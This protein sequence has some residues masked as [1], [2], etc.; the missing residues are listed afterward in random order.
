M[1]SKGRKSPGGIKN[2]ISAKT[3]RKATPW[4]ANAVKSIGLSYGEVFKEISPNIYDIA[5]VS[6]KS[7]NDLARS[8]RSSNVNNVTNSLSNNR[9]VKAGQNLIKNTIADLK[10]GNFNNKD[11]VDEAISNSMGGF[12]EFDS[13]TFFDDWDFE[14]GDASVQINNYSDTSGFSIAIDDSMKRNTEAQLKGH[15]ANIDTMIAISSAQMMQQ[16]QLNSEIIG[17]LS[18][19]SSGINALVEFNNSTLTSFIE[20]STAYMERLGSKVDEWSSGNSD[21]VDPASV[22]RDRNGG[23]NTSNYINLVKQNAKS[24][25]KNSDAGF[26]ADMMDDNM[27]A[28]VTANPL[29]AITQLALRQITP[30]MIKNSLAALDET[31]A[32]FIPTML[33]KVA[34]MADDQSFGIGA[35]IRRGFGKMFGLKI[36]RTNEFDMENKITDK[37]VPFDQITRHA[38][39]EVIP[40]YLREQTAYLEAIARNMGVNTRVSKN[41]A[42]V[43][44]YRR[45]RY[46][47]LRDVRE[48]VYGDIRN[49]TISR[50]E[51][52]KFGS[53]LRD[54]AIGN[55]ADQETYQRMLD[56]LFVA[57][58]RHGK[59]LNV[60]DQS[61]DSDLDKII[62]ALGYSPN[63]SNHLRAAL[64][65]VTA[66]PNIALNANAAIMQARLSRNGTINDMMSDPTAYNL[67]AAD[68][69]N[70]IDSG[71]KEVFKTSI[72]DP[73]KTKTGT[74]NDIMNDVRFILNRGIN[75]K[76]AGYG[77][78]RSLD[79][80]SAGVKNSVSN[81]NI[82]GSSSSDGEKSVYDGKNL[83]EADYERMMKEGSL[84][85]LFRSTENKKSNVV[86]G[87][88]NFM[89]ALAFGSGQQA[90]QELV[91]IAG[92]E[93]SKIG[94]KF[95]DEF[96]LPMKKSIFGDKDKDGY[97]RDGLF[98]G[99]QNKFIDA[100]RAFAR[101]FNGK[102]YTDSHGNKIA[103][104]KDGE[105]SVLGNIRKFTH[106]TI[107]I[108]GDYILGEKIYSR[109]EN[110]GIV[111]KGKRDKSKGNWLG[112]AIGVL[113][114]GFKGWTD[115]IFGEEMSEENKKKTLADIKKKVSDTLPSTITGAAGG[116]VFN[117]LAGS[118]LLGTLIG[119][120]MGGALLGATVG[121][122]SKSERFN[123]WLFG[124][125]FVDEDGNPQ[126]IEGLISKKV[127]DA[128]KDNK[129][130]IVGGAILG[131]GK[132]ML[133]GSGGGLLPSLVGGPFAGAIIGGSLSFLKNTD[134]FQKFLY[135][136]ADEGGWHKGIVNMFNGIFKNSETG[137]VSGRRLAGMNI[138][139][140]LGGGLTAAMVGK[141]GLLGAAVTPFGPIGGALAGLALSMKA[142]KKGF[143]Q[144]LFGSDEVDEDGNTRHKVG[145]LGKFAN[146]LDAELF[147]P[148]KSGMENFLDD[149]KN[150]IIDKVMA[151]VEFALEPLALTFKRVGEGIQTKI[152]NG[153]DAVTDMV[154]SRV[155]K[156]LNTIRDIIVKPIRNVFSIFFKGITGIAKTIIATPF[157]GLALATNFMDARAKRQSRK[158]VMRENRE[159]QG[160][161][162]G[163][164][165]N[166]AIRFRYGDAYEDAS[167][168]YVDYE[169]YENSR[170][171][172]QQRYAE[173]RDARLAET[174]RRK[175]ERRYGNKNRQLIAKVTG[176]LYDK[177]T[178]EN[179]AIA[180]QMWEEQLAKMSPLRRALANETLNFRG[181]AV[182]ERNESL[183]KKKN[184]LTVKNLL[185]NADKD[186]TS[187]EQKTAGNVIKLKDITTDIRSDIR[188]LNETLKKSNEKS[189][190]TLY[191]IL[192]KMPDFNGEGGGNKIAETLNKV[193]SDIVDNA[194]KIL[195]GHARGGK[196]KGG[197]VVVGENGPEIAFLPAGTEI[198]PN[199][200]SSNLFNNAK[201]SISRDQAAA[202]Y[203]ELK[204]QG[205]YE[206]QMKEKEQEQEKKYKNSLLTTVK[207]IK[208][209]TGDYT[210]GWKGIF[211]KKG[212]ITAGI[213]LLAPVALK[214][215]N[216]ILNLDFGGLLSSLLGFAG[217][218]ASRII[219]DT[220][221]G[222]QHLGDNDNSLDKIQENIEETGDLLHGD[223]LGW[224]APDGELDHQSGAKVNVLS[225]I[226]SYLKKGK[227]WLAKSQLGKDI[228]GA[229]G[230][231]KG[232]GKGLA[233]GIRGVKNTVG[234]AKNAFNIIRSGS[235]KGILVSAQSFKH[236]GMAGTWKEAITM[237]AEN[238]GVTLKSSGDD[239]AKT[240]S[241]NSKGV[242][243]VVKGAFSKLSEKLMAILKKYSKNGSK[244]AKYLDDIVEFVSK[245]SGKL[246]TKLQPL[247][248]KTG[249]LAATGVGLLA[250]EVVMVTVGAI[251]GAT[252]PA[253]LFQVDNEYVD[254]WMRAISAAIGGFAGSTV[255]SILD[256]VNELV[257]DILGLDI[258][259]EIAC[260]VYQILAGDTK[261][262][263]LLEGKDEFRSDFEA[264]EASEWNS[265]YQNYLSKNGL[266]EAD[267]SLDQFKEQ[268]N[269][270]NIS[271][272]ITSFADY[273]DQQHK[274]LG[275]RIMGGISSIGKGI[276][277][278]GNKIIGGAKNVITGAGSAVGNFAGNVASGIGKGI[279]AI[280]GGLM[281]IKDY[282]LEAITGYSTGVKEIVANFK[283]TDNTLFDYLKADIDTGISDENPFAKFVNG[284]LTVGKV[285]ML[286]KLVISGILGK[287]GNKI[288]DTFTSVADI[289]IDSAKTVISTVDTF[290]QYSHAGDVEGLNN[291]AIPD[292]KD[293]PINGLLHGIL[294]VAKIMNVPVAYLFKIGGSIK[295]AFV[296]M[297]NGVKSI[298]NTAN[299]NRVAFASY[300]L[301]GDTAGLSDY[302]I[303]I[304]EDTPLSGILGGLL[305]VEKLIWQI[306]AHIVGF[307]KGVVEKVTNVIGTA[308]E[309]GTDISTNVKNMANFISTGDVSGLHNYKMQKS[310]EGILGWLVDATGGVAKNIISIPTSIVGLGKAV[311][312][313]ISAAKEKVSDV[314]TDIKNYISDASAF[315]DPDKDMDGFSSIKFG[316][317]KNDPV[318]NIV[319]AVLS[320]IMGVY[321][322]IMR[323]INMAGNF[324]GD[325]VEW[326]K[327]KASGIKE[328]ASSAL[329]K[330]GNFISNGINSVGSAIMNF[331]RGGKGGRGGTGI[332]LPYYSQNDPR[333][334]N[335]NYGDESFGDAGCGP[336]AMAMV[337]S[338]L[339]GGRSGVSPVE[340]ANYAR[341]KGFRDS[342]GTN[343]NF[344]DSASR[345][346]GL[347]SQ[348]QY[349]PNESFISSQLGQGHPVILS[350][351]GG[352]STPYTR[353]GHYVVATGKDSSGNVMIS[354]PRGKQYSGKYSLRAVANNANIGWGI[355]RGGRGETVKTTISSSSS[356]K[357]MLNGF[358]F[359]LQGDSRWGAQLYTSRGDSSQT[360]KS[361]GCGIT[362][363]AMV[364]RSYGI[365][366]SPIDT[367]NY[368]LKNGFRTSNQGTSWGFFSSISKQYGLTCDDLGKSTS[369]VSQY[370]DKGWPVIASMGPGTFTKGGHFIVLVGK[371]TNGNIVV[372]DPASLERSQ[373]S[374]PLSLFGK[375]AK[376]FWA[377]GKNGQGSIN[378]IID[379]GTLNLAPMSGQSTYSEVD[380]TEG[381]PSSALNTIS[382][383]F[384]QFA[385]KAFNGLLTGNWDTNYDW[386]TNSSSS[387]SG[388]TNYAVES[389]NLNGN[390]NAQKIW[391]YL[392]GK[393]LTKEGTSGLM[394]NLMHESGLSPTNLQNS[395]ESSLGYTDSSYTS[396]VDSGKYG[397]FANDQAGYGLAQ[398]T[399]SGRKASLLQYKNQSGK[400]IGDLGMQLGFLSQELENSYPD[401][402]NTLKSTNSI[403]SAS[404]IVLTKFE[405]PKDQ[406]QSVKNKRAG[407][408]Q[409]VYNQYGSSDVVYTGGGRGE[410][411][412]N[413]ANKSFGLISK[414][415]GQSSYH[416]SNYGGRGSIENS[417]MI[418]L[419]R[420]MITLLEQIS[421]SSMSSDKKLDQLGNISG[422]QVNLTSVNTGGKGGKVQPV[423]LPTGNEQ[424]VT[425]PNRNSQIA[426][427][428]ALGF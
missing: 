114:D 111:W 308:K 281:S 349:R 186:D 331:G 347:N 424:V 245:Y 376:N 396:A 85:E 419:M 150:F 411:C 72:G 89:S 357:D 421:N 67:Y 230:A 335:M 360:I 426:R 80:G 7:V 138:L 242:I 402:W 179:R 102:G 272:D 427:K 197:P 285:T 9:Y 53:A 359:L 373:A 88:Q 134:M 107:G 312:D 229:W 301:S 191:S 94:K 44:D 104:K 418:E 355:S 97:A 368:S 279:S 16:Q 152:M 343:W 37:A 126:H 198:V 348:R 282:A 62:S 227:N 213:M 407:Y 69:G 154:K 204:K 313:T 208:E 277:S 372:N 92:G 334:K 240:V 140:A 60:T 231:A 123:K 148:M 34:D 286:P 199:A 391:N 219:E 399:S 228:K 247:L 56:D 130:G 165:N 311:K 172:R 26:L 321:V 42:E 413:T 161:L 136:D 222:Q 289:A 290:R 292:N 141:M 190:E 155:D 350:G 278:V 31:L 57:M 137:E 217:D 364:L 325:K 410:G 269:A 168:R 158:Q 258:F 100:Y 175:D 91:N 305:N 328:G 184:K 397:N 393:G 409:Q 250:N 404:D 24:Y 256:I 342:S 241:K 82:S 414:S 59:F 87:L 336:D 235:A 78:Y 341:S 415:H 40:K 23:I 76:I 211:G 66:D 132:N 96:L 99:M 390:T 401:V 412:R 375:E 183:K 297:V 54:K 379:A 263:T 45:G 307:G 280:G 403:Q 234:T 75:V 212:L 127:Q 302:A 303:G 298:F 318:N 215:L 64:K 108:L 253:R 382:S 254:G 369:K 83:T 221:Y 121:T 232:V 255:G 192:S 21:R 149:S 329:N 423:I 362:S 147:Q 162:R 353:G 166:M 244:L 267:M 181:V 12:E 238:A 306:P 422:S 264:N 296:G 293:N 283:N 133:F 220:V 274:T 29:G 209:I 194:K 15:K 294:S 420:T 189:N 4:L 3:K 248:T 317:D 115:A 389:V 326:V 316:K 380:V 223:I 95:S 224:I 332:A 58:E 288:K 361:S 428:I 128:F 14:D 176:N 265:E 144:F 105:E 153:V 38:I 408:G 139:G 188:N 363:M 417:T 157:Q 145:I 320:K 93:F 304:P 180:Q 216:K 327:N 287:V 266:T 309:V 324:I 187:V 182:D 5:S 52:S 143:H 48:D 344:I 146:M 395:Y 113:Q 291:V 90:F 50:M 65:S 33:A 271:V 371:D 77:S 142:S 124:E 151:P 11:R 206:T 226:P 43:F 262:E 30:K 79:S 32:G 300:A 225:H 36:N 2:T 338:G 178:E 323:A 120:P 345:D 205:S 386:G 22:F 400:S 385:E 299:Q 243:N 122:L 315:T 405:R 171:E 195:P 81:A 394:G 47:S 322:R 118:S 218:T 71:I 310:N 20:S 6:A 261:Y 314:K 207:D 319:G 203:E 236:S 246:A 39:T 367:A 8:A 135:G 112:K 51:N 84:D 406:S 156:T 384:S 25:F 49:T 98:S 61:K 177:D 169:Q 27:L 378:H 109:D 398:W 214:A 196:T 174:Q 119:G 270:G 339:G 260:T 55:Q 388:S 200:K 202:D 74:L 425:A 63:M 1:P 387:S 381:S 333:W 159:N 233:T 259:H 275:S 365:N 170:S 86:T 273:N 366:V 101:E 131:L 370:L 185:D 46:R 13:G 41:N 340:M 125:D 358:P 70:T 383:F 351:Q 239:V 28:M 295:D 374:Y 173:E 276:G 356:G 110:G 167:H 10:T 164:L 68:V 352:P 330:A 416:Y 257:V 377:F 116:V 117:A 201:N 252:G 268:A 346:Y 251:N 237:G 392:R 193:K 129:T 19:I 35:A 284:M 18:N 337:A 210:K 103:D 17:H 160:F 106:D 73:E 163:T 354:D 249:A